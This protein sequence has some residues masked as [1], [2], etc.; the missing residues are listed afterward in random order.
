MKT[1]SRNGRYYRVCDPL[2]V[3]CCSAEFAARYGGRWNAPQ[4]FPV[5]YLNAGVATAKANALRTYDGE[6]FGLF[7]LNPTARPHLQIVEIKRHDAVDAVTDEGLRELGLPPTY[8]CGITHDVCRPIG[9]KIY[10]AGHP[11]IAY[12]SAALSGGEELALLHLD[13]A[14]KRS[15]HPFNEWFLDEVSR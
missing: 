5:L 14:T 8:P 6:A 9:K 11:S 13:L 3:D 15:R 2:W 12:R 1:L 10:D 4:S 7:D